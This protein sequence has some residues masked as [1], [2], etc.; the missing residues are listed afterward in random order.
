MT[1]DPRVVGD[2]VAAALALL[3][4]A[5]PKGEDSKKTVDASLLDR[6]SEALIPLG[7]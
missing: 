7:A 6:L 4:N 1:Y 5:T 3:E 2:L